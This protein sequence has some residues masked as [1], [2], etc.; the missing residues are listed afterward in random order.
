MCVSSY[1]TQWH[2]IVGT[3]KYNERCDVTDQTQFCHPLTDDVT[4]TAIAR[5][6]SSIYW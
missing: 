5:Y 6:A 4:V 2:T 3:D 1:V